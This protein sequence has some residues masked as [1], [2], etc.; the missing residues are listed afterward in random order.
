[1][2]G[3]TAADVRRSLPAGDA[4]AT[5]NDPGDVIA[6]GIVGATVG[7]AVGWSVWLVHAG[8]RSLPGS[9]R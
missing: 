8:R 3:S 4:T 2:T 5:R 7:E 9:S 6:G 1:M